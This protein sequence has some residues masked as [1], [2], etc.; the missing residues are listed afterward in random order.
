MVAALGGYIC[1]DEKLDSTEL[2]GCMLL[3]GAVLFSAYDSMNV[4]EEKEEEGDISSHATGIEMAQMSQVA[5]TTTTLMPQYGSSNIGNTHDY[6]Q[7]T[8]ATEKTR[9]IS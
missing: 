7:I 4:T 3:L 2:L 5:L 8:K 6:T 1:L 9:L